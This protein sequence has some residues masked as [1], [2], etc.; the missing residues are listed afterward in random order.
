MVITE[1]SVILPYKFMVR[2]KFWC[3]VSIGSGKPI[4]YSYEKGVHRIEYWDFRNKKMIK[5]GAPIIEKPMMD[6]YY[7]EHTG[8]VLDF[9]R[10]K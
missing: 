1:V 10:V 3:V 5:S 2:G 9:R 7:P 6:V 4:Q 8:I